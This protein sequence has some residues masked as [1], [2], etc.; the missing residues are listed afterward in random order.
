MA[1]LFPGQSLAFEERSRSY[2]VGKEKDIVNETKNLGMSY[3]EIKLYVKKPDVLRKKVKERLGLEDL[4]L[5]VV[6]RGIMD[7][8]DRGKL[9]KKFERSFPPLRD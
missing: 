8:L 2:V 4:E 1:Y 7:D 3:E 9:G 6:L 5:D